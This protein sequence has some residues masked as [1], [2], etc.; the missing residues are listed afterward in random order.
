I[1]ANG[2]QVTEKIL[3]KI[4][5]W[6][7][8]RNIQLIPVVVPFE[9]C[10]GPKNWK[11][12][13]SGSSPPKMIRDY[14]ERRLGRLFDRLSLPA[15]LLKEPFERNID[16]VLPFIGGHFNPEGHRVTADAIY[17]K[18]VEIGLVH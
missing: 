17:S 5:S 9:A 15:V 18:M 10:V 11:S 4:A 12:F 3:E 7:S 2:W 16:V 14:P 1:V 13:A 6:C 8:E